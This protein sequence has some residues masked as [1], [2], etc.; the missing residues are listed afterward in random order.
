MLQVLPDEATARAGI[1]APPERRREFLWTLRTG[2]AAGRLALGVLSQL[3]EPGGLPAERGAFGAILR[4]VL[5]YD[6]CLK[7]PHAPTNTTST[8]RF[9]TL[10]TILYSRERQRE[11]KME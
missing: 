3:M 5:L 2:G 6:A 1:S 10:Y 7:I 4:Y 8:W 9:N 11:R